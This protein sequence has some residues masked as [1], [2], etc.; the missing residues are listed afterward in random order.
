M[1]STLI[2]VCTLSCARRN[3]L[4]CLIFYTFT[5]GLLDCVGINSKWRARRGGR[6]GNSGRCSSG[7]NYGCRLQWDAYAL[8]RLALGRRQEK[9]SLG[10]NFAHAY[11]RRTALPHNRY[12]FEILGR[13]IRR[14]NSIK[15][16][17]THQPIIL[18]QIRKTTERTVRREGAHSHPPP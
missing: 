16:K 7:R 4:D 14:N 3:N 1:L 18:Q 8:F 17:S 13:I 9:D 5:L 11:V 2:R 10:N 12:G 6:S 15:N